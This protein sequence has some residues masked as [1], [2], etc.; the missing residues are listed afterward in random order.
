M[1]RNIF[2]AIHRDTGYQEWMGEVYAR[3]AL[4]THLLNSEFFR[5]LN[6]EQRKRV[7]ASAQLRVSE[8]GMILVDEGDPSDSVFIIRNGMVQV[9]K[10]A[11]VSL[12][13]GQIADWQALCRDLLRGAEETS[14]APAAETRKPPATPSGKPAASP[15][16]ILAA[17]RNKQKAP[18]NDAPPKADVPATPR[19][20]KGKSKGK[21]DVADILAAAGKAPSPAKQSAAAKQGTPAKPIADKKA[22]PSSAQRTESKPPAAGDAKVSAARA[23]VWAMLGKDVQAA[24]RRVAAG[25]DVASEEQAALLAKLLFLMRRS[26]SVGREGA[27]IRGPVDRSPN[28][29]SFLS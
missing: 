28:G 15:A 21:M 6:D 2:D 23:K 17:L 18:P 19:A 13:A 12:K 5:A 9:V 27:P 22:A 3:R 7:C 26:R 8:P 29:D 24:A 11:N 14:P 16:D 25:E 4:E 10:E 1:S 20:D